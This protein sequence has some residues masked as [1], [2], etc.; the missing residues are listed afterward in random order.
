M[1][2]WRSEV[3]ATKKIKEIMK[4]KNKGEKKKK[5]KEMVRGKRERRAVWWF[6][7]VWRRFGVAACG[8]VGVL[9]WRREGVA[10][11]GSIDVWKWRSVGD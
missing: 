5:K 10:A 8:S 7:C 6:L 4:L 2:E 9:E 3:V 11:C 1:W